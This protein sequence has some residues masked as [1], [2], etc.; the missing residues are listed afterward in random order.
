M[1]ILQFKEKLITR[2]KIDPIREPDKILNENNFEQYFVLPIAFEINKTETDV[3]LYSHPWGNEVRCTPD[4]ENAREG[5]GHIQESC[6]K[7]WWESKKWGTVNAFGTQN[8]FDLVAEDTNNCK[9]AIEIKFIS[10]MKGRRPNGEIQRFLGQCAMAASKFNFVTGVCAYIGEL[11]P[12]YDKD[13]EKFMHWAEKNNINI[14][15]RS[16]SK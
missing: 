8:N 7:C 14:I 16:V 2:L 9:L 11:N 1:P 13:T 6:D 5:K 4:C 10:F 15:F 12:K 3:F